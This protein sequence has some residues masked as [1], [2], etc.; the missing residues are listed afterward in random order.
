MSLLD[1][2]KTVLTIAVEIN[3]ANQTDRDRRQDRERIQ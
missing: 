1:I 2:A 3:T